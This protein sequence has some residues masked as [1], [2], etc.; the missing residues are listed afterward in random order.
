MK[1]E[2]DNSKIVVFTGAGISAESGLKTF[3]DMNG[4]WN[5]FKIDEVATPEAWN[6]NPK[7]VLNFYN[8]RKKQALEAKPNNAH[9]ALALLEKQFNVIIIT[10]NVDDLHERAGSSNIIHLHGQLNLSRSSADENLIYETKGPILIGDKCVKGSQLRPN[11]VWFGENI[12]N[13][14]AARDHLVTASKIMVVGTSLSVFP[15]AGMLKKARN[16]AEKIVISPELE[17]QPY[18]F[19]WLRGKA[20]SLVPSTVEHWLNGRK[21]I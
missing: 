9:L 4:L 17:K 6:N 2:I 21:A 14:D 8:E 18:G 20:C 5:E 7:L 1:Q 10:Q 13:Y 16:M 15:A 3:R 19:K 11:V 12:Q